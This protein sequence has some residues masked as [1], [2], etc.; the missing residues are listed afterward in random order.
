VFPKDL[1]FLSNRRAIDKRQRRQGE[2]LVHR[3]LGGEARPCA[4][5]AEAVR[6]SRRGGV[7]EMGTGQFF[8][9]S[10]SSA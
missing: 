10:V 3:G 4:V 9:S 7:S 6:A 5:W 2:L 8:L 1:T